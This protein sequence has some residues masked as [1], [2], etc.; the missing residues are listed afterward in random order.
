M[1]KRSVTI[2]SFGVTQVEAFDRLLV[3]PPAAPP[4]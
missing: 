1:T 3:L 4:R 2:T